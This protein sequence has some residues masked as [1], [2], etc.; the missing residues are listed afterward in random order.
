MGG[1]PWRQMAVYIAESWRGPYRLR[2][3]TP[4]FGEDAYVWEGPRAFHM[5]V[6]SMHPH[7]IPTVAWSPD[8]INWIPNGYAGPDRGEP[9]PRQSFSH[10]IELESG[11]S[12]QL[13]RRERHQ[14]LVDPVT[15]EPLALYNGATLPGKGDYSFTAV[16]L[17][18]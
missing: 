11:S 7:K 16:Q 8:G 18:R 17:I 14:V 9:V 10:T 1:S 13:A 3:L 12:L 5:I 15:R 2:T 6:H 4:V